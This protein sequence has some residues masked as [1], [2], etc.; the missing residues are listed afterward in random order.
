MIK[1]DRWLILIDQWRMNAWL[2]LRCLLQCAEWAEW[3][4]FCVQWLQCTLCTLCTLLQFSIVCCNIQCCSEVD[5]VL[6]C[7]LC[8]L[9]TVP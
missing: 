4:Q 5:A 2:Q 3:A 7:A 8:A 1:D 9:C 6:Q